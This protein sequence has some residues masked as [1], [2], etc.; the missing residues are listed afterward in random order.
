MWWLRTRPLTRPV[1]PYPL[2][3]STI[4]LWTSLP[5]SNPTVDISLGMS[6]PRHRNTLDTGP[7]IHREMARQTLNRDAFKKRISVL[8]ISVPAEKA[9]RILKSQELRGY[10][11]TTAGFHSV[12][13]GLRRSIINVP[14]TKSVIHDPS[15]P[16]KRLVLFRVPE[17]GQ[18]LW[19]CVSH[20]Q[21]LS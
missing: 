13:T 8:A 14:K 2:P 15:N 6:S 3:L 7:P 20:V 17:F 21:D 9:S 1:P 16:D 11:R 10:V 5:F 12:L 4:S 19:C 18:F